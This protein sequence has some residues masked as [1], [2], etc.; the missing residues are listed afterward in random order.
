MTDQT[1][2]CSPAKE[3]TKGEILLVGVMFKG[4]VLFFIYLMVDVPEP[5]IWLHEGL[6]IWLIKTLKMGS[7]TMAILFGITGVLLTLR[8]I[9]LEVA[10]KLKS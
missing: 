6:P 5:G 4:A 2:S 10:E 7:L 9:A 1:V 8:E 3:P